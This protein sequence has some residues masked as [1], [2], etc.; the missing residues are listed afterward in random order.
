MPKRNVV[1]IDEDKCDGCGQCVTACAEGAIAVVDGK[2]RLVSDSYCD[3]LG[4]CLGTCPQ[5]AITVEEREA[6]AFDE[7]A[8]KRHL[9]AHENGKA[10]A[11]EP[12]PCGCPGT[13]MRALGTA[14][15]APAERH[16]PAA[17]GDSQLSHW[18]VQ[19]RLVP[20]HAPFLKGADLLVA[21]DCTAFALSDLHRRYL[22]G[23]AVLVG[24]PKLDDLAF[25]RQKLADVLREAA[26][27]SVTV[28][29]MEVPCCG[30]IAHAVREARDEVAPDLPLEIH[31]VA[32]DGGRIEVEIVPA[33]AAAAGEKT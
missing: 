11:A 32:I 26:P 1:K 6:E 2:A 8:V 14:N 9:A 28:L 18:P 23:R 33:G 24:C 30:G 7:E 5:D 29:R 25:Y 22:S 15:H 27:R 4:A 17:A 13:A 16:G 10:A 3:G 12:L 31:T 20:P 19:L 21:A